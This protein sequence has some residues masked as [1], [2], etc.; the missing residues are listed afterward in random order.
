MRLTIS[1][2]MFDDSVLGV[3]V[4]PVEPASKELSRELVRELFTLVTPETSD[5]FHPTFL[6]VLSEARWI[7]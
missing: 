6:E 4:D 3:A 5:I 2:F 1:E 7:T